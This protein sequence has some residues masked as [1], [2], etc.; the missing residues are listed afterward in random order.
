[1]PKA[2]RRMLTHRLHGAEGGAGVRGSLPAAA[3]QAASSTP[4]VKGS[5]ASYGT[6]NLQRRRAAGCFDP[7]GSRQMDTL[8]CPL[9]S[10]PAE[11][12]KGWHCHPQKPLILLF[13]FSKFR[14]ALRD[15]FPSAPASPQS[16]AVFFPAADSIWFPQNAP[17]TAPGISGTH[18]RDLPE[19]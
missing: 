18:R 19:N 17:D 6:S 4:E 2:R 15:R 14:S 13:P 12:K 8:A 11:I 16:A 7:R 3:A 10:L 9:D 1:M 5:A